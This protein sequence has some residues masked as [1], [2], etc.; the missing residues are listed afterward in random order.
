MTDSAPPLVHLLH[1]YGLRRVQ[2][3]SA[4]SVNMKT[5]G[6]LCRGEYLGM[7][8]ETLCRVAVVLGV[9]PAVSKAPLRK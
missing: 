3:A 5:I 1:A 7:K 4:A 2:L 9:A 8:V 6:K